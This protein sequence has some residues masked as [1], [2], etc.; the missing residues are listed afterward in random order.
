MKEQI[1]RL[2]EKEVDM[3]RGILLSVIRNHGQNDW[4]WGDKL[5]HKIPDCIFLLN[6]LEKKKK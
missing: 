2:D 1:I 4:F 5:Q 6:K 3:L